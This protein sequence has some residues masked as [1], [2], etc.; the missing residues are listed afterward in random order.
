MSDSC[1]PRDCSL[2]GSSVHGISQARVLQWVAFSSPGFL[3][4]PEIETESLISPELADNFF[5]FNHW[6]HLGMPFLILLRSYFIYAI[7][8]FIASD[9]SAVN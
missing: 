9:V 7:N 3:P 4:G 6:C 1:N 5:F 8:Y 2:P